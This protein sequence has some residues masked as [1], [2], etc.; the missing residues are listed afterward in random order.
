MRTTLVV[1][2]V[3]L[4]LAAVLLLVAGFGAL[5]RRRLLGGLVTSLVAALC[6][7]LAALAATLSVALRGYHAFT[8]EEIAATVRT[9][10][11]GPQRFRAT[12]TLAR[13][14]LHMLELDGDELYVDAHILKWHPIV[15]LLGLHT[16]YELD[17]IAGRYHALAD[18]RSRPRTVHS[19]AVDKPIDA[20]DLARRYRLLAPLV[21]A[22]YGSATFIGAREPAEYEVRVSTSGLLVRRRSEATR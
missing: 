18:E 7:A 3:L 19:L 14:S 8:H 22:E 6:L 16:A 4:A 17:R 21:D 15:N 5:K 9:E 13:G 12:V 20:F 10:P 1:V 11:T 2:A